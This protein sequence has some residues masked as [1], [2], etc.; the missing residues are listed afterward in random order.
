MCL[1]PDVCCLWG[2][3]QCFESYYFSHSLIASE[4]ERTHKHT[5]VH[6]QP[7]PNPAGHGWSRSC[8]RGEKMGIPPRHS[9][10]S[11]GLCWA[12]M[13]VLFVPPLSEMP[14]LMALRKRAQ[15]EK[16]LAGAKVVGCTHITAQT[17]V[18]LLLN[19]DLQHKTKRHNQMKTRGFTM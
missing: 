7:Q 15:G 6:T 19:G 10:S 11:W 12:L 13:C 18:S 16:P 14:A 1:V 5:L 9:S 3:K 4:W 2:Q 17:A 8:S